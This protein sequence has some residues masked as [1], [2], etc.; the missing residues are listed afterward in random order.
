MRLL[1][2]QRNQVGA[3]W[4]DSRVLNLPFAI[5]GVRRW[6]D[7]VRL[8]LDASDHNGVC[9][10]FFHVSKYCDDLHLHQRCIVFRGTPTPPTSGPKSDFD[11]ESM[12]LFCDCDILIVYLRM[13]W[14]NYSEWCSYFSPNLRKTRC[15][16]EYWDANELL[17]L[18]LTVH[19]CWFLC[20]S[21]ETHGSFHIWR[22]N[23]FILVTP[24][25]DG[26]LYRSIAT[27]LR[28]VSRSGATAEIARVGGRS[29]RR[30]RSFMVIDVGMQLKARMRLP[31][32]E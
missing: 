8:R 9:K 19:A 31:I 27:W 5:G 28:Q 1:C 4:R 26:R 18:T 32:S 11:S 21:I 7:N 6:K 24:P 30:S 12:D 16:F 20:H 15:R 17:R 22:R 25:P 29:L 13:T 10:I 14:E 2:T 3:S 23:K